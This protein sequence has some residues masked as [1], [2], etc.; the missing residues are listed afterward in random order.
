MLQTSPVT[1]DS[2][3]I[4]TFVRL[5]DDFRACVIAIDGD[6]QPI[7]YLRWLAKRSQE[8]D[9]NA[10]VIDMVSVVEAYRRHGV[11]RRLLEE[12][13]RV[14]AEEGWTAP[15]HN[16]HRSALGDAWA[17]GI[18]AEPAMAVDELGWGPQ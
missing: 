2:V 14:S 17:Q 16:R 12:A 8:Q 4:A 15:K 7:G 1:D 18:G 6:L 10:G 5:D 3:T 13:E 9:F 11:A